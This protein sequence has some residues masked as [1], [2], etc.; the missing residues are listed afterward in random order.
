MSDT[1]T[2]DAQIAEALIGE[3]AERFVKSELGQV[4]IGF[5]QQ[6]VDAARD[7]IEKVDPTATE[8]IRQLQFKA[9]F[10]REFKAWLVELIEKGIEAQKVIKNES[11]N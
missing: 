10:G 3:D 6:E 8:K 9:R 2:G 4:I 5:A 7:E 1:L 11:S